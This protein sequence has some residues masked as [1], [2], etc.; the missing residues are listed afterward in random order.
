MSAFVLQRSVEGLRIGAVYYPCVPDSEDDA[1][2][3]KQER[4][5]ANFTRSSGCFSLK[6]LRHCSL[7]S[8][9]FVWLRHRRFGKPPVR[10]SV[11]AASGRFTAAAGCRIGGTTVALGA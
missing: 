8:Q 10:A 5:Q 7:F 1:T 9:P 11:A 4:H 2:A 6:P 3:T